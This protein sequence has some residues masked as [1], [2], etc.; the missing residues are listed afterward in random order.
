MTVE[1]LCSPAAVHDAEG[2]FASE[3]SAAIWEGIVLLPDWSFLK[4]ATRLRSSR[5]SLTSKSLI[6]WTACPSPSKPLTSADTSSG[7]PTDSGNVKA[8]NRECDSINR[9]IPRSPFLF[10]LWQSSPQRKRL[11]LRF[12]SSSTSSSP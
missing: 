11:P 2:V 8:L 6:M 10:S 1:V 9:L 12:E 4:A 5:T 7:M 3:E